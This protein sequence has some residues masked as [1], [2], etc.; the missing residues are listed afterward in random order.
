M[1]ETHDFPEYPDGSGR[2]EIRLTGH[3]D[4]RWTD[5]FEGLTV[6]LEENGETVL[7]GPVADQP[8]LHGLLKKIRDLGI[9]LVSVNLVRPGRAKTQEVKP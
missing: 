8:A 1:C 5:R 3:L 4:E 6:T 2:Y 9:P 7:C